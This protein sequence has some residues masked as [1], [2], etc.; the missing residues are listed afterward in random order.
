MLLCGV[1]QVLTVQI[2]MRRPVSVHVLKVPLKGNL[3]LH[4]TASLAVR[5]S[6][7]GGKFGVILHAKSNSLLKI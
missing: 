1:Q 3:R 7:H 5:L 6:L 4:A 2:N